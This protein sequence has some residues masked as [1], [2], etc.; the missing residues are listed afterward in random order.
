MRVSLYILGI[1]VI[2]A[3]VIFK[4]SSKLQLCSTF[5]IFCKS[6]GNSASYGICC[7]F[8]VVNFV[9]FTERCTVVQSAAL[10]LHV[11][12]LS[13]CWST[14]DNI[15]ETPKV[16]EKVLLWRAYRNSPT[17]VRTV[18]SPTPYS[19]LFPKIGGFITPTRKT[20][21]SNCYYL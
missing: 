11:V 6:A 14:S 9:V 20:Q 7:V 19:L 1:F 21:N 12:R 3:A 5:R 18:P 13:V 15:S 8:G 2:E 17:L 4:S 10:R 16:E